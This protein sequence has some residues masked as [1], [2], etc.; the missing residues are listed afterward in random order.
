MY[1]KPHFLSKQMW[2]LSLGSSWLVYF[3]L[4]HFEKSANSVSFL[5]NR[6]YFPYPAISSNFQMWFVLQQVSAASSPLLK[7]ELLK[8]QLQYLC[9]ASFPSTKVPATSKSISN[10]CHI[11]SQIFMFRLTKSLAAQL[12]WDYF[13]SRCLRSTMLHWAITDFCKGEHKR[14]NEPWK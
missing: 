13:C 5:F 14:G 11:C 3:S 2:G 8:L 4:Q 6:Q 7:S 1:R 10:D 12:E 9:V